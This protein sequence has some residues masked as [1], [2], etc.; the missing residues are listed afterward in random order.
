[1]TSPCDHERGPG[2]PELGIPWEGRGE[3]RTPAGR[4]RLVAPPPP[5][6]PPARR[7]PDAHVQPSQPPPPDR[8]EA[9][10]I[11]PIVAPPFCAADWSTPPQRRRPGRRCLVRRRALLVATDLP[12]AIATTPRRAGRL[13][14]DTRTPAGRHRLVAPPPPIPL[15]AR[16]TPDA[17]VQLSQPP[18]PD[19]TEASSI[20]PTV[21]PPF[22]AAEWS[23]PPQRRR[24]WTLLPGP[25]SR[26]PGYDRP[27]RRDRCHAETR[28]LPP[29][30]CL[31]PVARRSF[32]SPPNAG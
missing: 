24:P 2:I 12:G 31:T 30:W 19:R 8:T 7:T 13:R 3:E 20:P 15:P 26:P 18:P 1:M 11:R 25:P 9:P 14:S 23:T 5:I 16:R 10:S 29:L 21:A 22:C 32:P 6:P 27:A 4:H 28:R 17:H